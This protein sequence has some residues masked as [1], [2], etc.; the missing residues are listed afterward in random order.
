M[1]QPGYNLLR[2]RTTMILAQWVPIKPEEID[3]TAVYQIFTHL[4]SKA[5]TLNDHVV[6]VTAGRQL[7]MVLEPF[8]FNYNDFAPY[9]TPILSSIMLLTAETDL[10]ETKMALLETVRV[11]VT[12]LEGQIEPY[13]QGIMSMLPPL[14]GQ[15]GEEHLMKQ[16]ILTMITA[17]VN[18]LR[19][20][21]LAYHSAVLP[22]IHD[23][24]QPES[25]AAVYLLEEALE[26]WKAILIQTPT[27]KP[28]ASQELLAMSS[29][30]LPLLEMGS[31][32]LQQIFDIIESYTV[33]SPSTVLAPAFLT[34][35]STSLKT[36][37]PMLASSRARDAALAPHVLEYLSSTLTIPAYFDGA[38]SQQAI[39]H[40]FSALVNT[41]YLQ[42]LL[43]IIHVAYDYHQ[44]PRLNRRP[45]DVIGP[46]ET[47]LFSLLARLALLS[48]SLF[49]QAINGCS[50][51]ANA[52]NW[53]IVEWIGHFDAVGDVLRK[54]LQILGVTALLTPSAGPPPIMLEQLQSL[55]TAWTDIAI[56][57]G[58]EAADD[59]QGDYLWYSSKPTDT[60]EWPDATPEDGRK[61]I[62]SNHDPI[63][64]INVRYFVAE[65]LREVMQS[66]P[67][68]QAAFEQEWLSRVDEAV[69]KGFVDLKI[70]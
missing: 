58:E 47:S 32:L 49:I 17:I 53:L 42:E 21:S 24:V 54:K 34:P 69:M 29:S 44:D 30:L 10:S 31:E 40:L 13:A 66:W 14:W 68:G 56:E 4:L 23:S 18:S 33:L 61:R 2:R 35:C 63:F 64:A 5:D 1:K 11:A 50:S 70:L 28:G 57:L 8:E 38:T 62:V 3:R 39:Q 36:Q 59:A 9:A 25:E 65:R 52:L 26:L 46:G 55:I 27:D 7:R 60:P 43:R 67:G 20:K 16:A 6:R 37:L 51:D 19:E 45:P 12:K 22:L 15:S 41:G 48:P